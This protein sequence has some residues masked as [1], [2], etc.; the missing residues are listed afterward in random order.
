MRI[1]ERRNQP[2]NLSTQFVVTTTNGH[3]IHFQF[4]AF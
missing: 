1:D 2:N 3:S 4:Q